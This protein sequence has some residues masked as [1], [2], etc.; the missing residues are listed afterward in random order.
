MLWI[1]QVWGVEMPNEH[2]VIEYGTAQELACIFQ[3]A[4]KD[5]DLPFDPAS[6]GVKATYNTQTHVI[7]LLD[8]I[9]LSD[10]D[11][12][13]ILVHELSHHVQTANGM[14]YVCVGE[15][16]RAAYMIQMQW[17]EE[18]G[19]ESWAAMERITGLDAFSIFLITRCYD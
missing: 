13:S 8:D 10:P 19:I 6:P 1:S 12:I 2:P 5:C 17:L 15:L 4:K 18:Q 9:D 7:H 16:E 14:K 3:T 11:Q